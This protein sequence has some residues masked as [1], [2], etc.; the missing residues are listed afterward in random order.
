MENQASSKSVI[1]NYG[2]YYGIVSVLIAV[3]F[4]ALDM[5]LQQGLINMVVGLGVMLAFIVLAQKKFKLDNLNILSFW[6]AVKIGMGTVLIGALISIIYNQV[7]INFIEPDFMNQ[8]MEIQRQAW[9]DNNMTSEQI[10]AAEDMT[11]RFSGPFISS[12][13]VI[14]AA[15]FFSFVL[16][17]IS[18]AIMKRTEEDGY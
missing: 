10:E 15:A 17:M 2:L 9:E 3:I 18:G 16:S 5:H 11:K 1:L 8:V 7:F 14:L 12:A 13:F 6:Q 4:Y